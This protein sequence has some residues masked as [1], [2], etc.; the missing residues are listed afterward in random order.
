M[1]EWV[2]RESMPTPK[3]DFQA[4]GVGDEIYAVTGSHDLT[5]DTVDVYENG[6][7]SMETGAAHSH[8]TRLHR[9]RHAGR[10]D[11]RRGWQADTLTRGK[12]GEW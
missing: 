8:Q 10:A 1:G 9:R 5:I 12:G 2:K 11:L 6:E 4:V 7:R 3:H